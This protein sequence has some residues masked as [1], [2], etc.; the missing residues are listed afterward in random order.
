MDET[1]AELAA[2]A[3]SQPE[4]NPR[5]PVRDDEAIDEPSSK[6]DSD[7]PT[8]ILPPAPVNGSP[9]WQSLTDKAL[10]FL[11]HASNETLG[12]C[13]AGLGATTYLVLGRVGLVIIGVAGGVVLH[14]TWEGIRGDDRDEATKKAIQERQRESAVDVARRVLEWRR[15]GQ[16]EEQA[17]DTRVYA[18]QALDYSRFGPETSAALDTFTNAVI[19]DYVHYWYDA[20][21][22]GELSFPAACRRTFTAFVL[23][24]SGHLE[25]K[26]PADAFLDFVGNAS[27]MIIVF[28]TELSVALN[29]SPNKPAEEAV[30]AYLELKPE[31]SLSAMLNQESQKTKMSD[32]A[33]DILQSYLDP[34]SYNCPPVHIFLKEVLAQ[35]VLGYTVDMCSNPD[36][37]NDWIVYGLEESETTKEV[38]D[39]VDAGVEGRPQRETRSSVKQDVETAVAVEDKKEATGGIGV[40][41]TAGTTASHRRTASRAEQIMEEDMR[42]EVER[43]N[44]MIFEADRRKAEEEDQKRRSTPTIAEDSSDGTTQGVG[45]PSSSQSGRDRVEEDSTTSLEESVIDE[46]PTTPS[47]QFTSFDQLVPISPPTALAESPGRPLPRPQSGLL[48]LHNASISIHDD[49]QPSDRASIKAKPTFDYLIQIEPSSSNFPGWMIVR[50]Y[51]DFETL[52]EVLKRIAVITGV[53]FSSSHAELPRWKTNTKATLRTE[54]ERY[55]TDAVRFQPLAES[56]GMKRFL[57]K[58]Q[59]L[60]KSPGGSQKGFGW[61][62]PDALGKIS[63]DMFNVLTKAPKQVAGGGKAVFGGVAG[64]VGAGK[65]PNV[66]QTNLSRTATNTSTDASDRSKPRPSIGNGPTSMTDSYISTSSA[67]RASQDSVRA[68]PQPVQEQRRGSAFSTAS[69]DMR[70]RPSESPSRPLSITSQNGHLPAVEAS[71]STSVASL[72]PKDLSLDETIHLPPPPSEM[73]EDYSSPTSPGKDNIDTFRSTNLNQRLSQTMTREEQPPTPPR[74]QLPQLKVESKPKAPLT[75]RETAVAV[76][77]MF[78]VITQLYTLSGAWQIR[79]TLLQAAKTFLLRPGNPQLSTIKDLLQT[80]LIESNL[81]DAGLAHHILKLRE[82]TL[83]T[84]EETEAWK[85]DFPA[86]SAEQKEELRIK[87]R[88]LLINKGMPQALTSVMG[89]AASGE[90]LGKVFDCL[91]IPAVS[92]GLIFGLMLQ[93]L[94]VVTQ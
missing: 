1:T 48:T 60:S 89:A 66:S 86:K 43:L 91:Q 14:A 5:V 71:P 29:A 59:G 81:S 53:P 16:A 31:S 57:E 67:G 13:L 11:S 94:R 19:K 77:I 55:L 46:N 7:A 27:S 21:I 15:N 40:T 75:E 6:T 72:A 10:F 88:R 44:E 65:K 52:H 33:E 93:A 58:D 78:A 2:P 50:K 54:L 74:P 4:G 83:P 61:P 36:W 17:E 37:I 22:P 30:S 79:R 26:R 87:A 62:T 39:I 45:T 28:L 80:S 84:A 20:T 47:M 49:S 68:I 85:R 63:G 9:T 42:R 76:E 92:R 38:M 12:A 69:S 8:N 35:L 23:S 73:P 34:K 32:A 51:V 64:L 82:N 56:E 41:D 24:L 90:A 70:P 18:N 3:S 25:R